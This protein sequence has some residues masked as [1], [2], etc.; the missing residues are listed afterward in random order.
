MLALLPITFIL[1]LLW[2]GRGG[3]KKKE[4]LIDFLVCSQLWDL[5][6]ISNKLLLPLN[7]T[8]GYKSPA[9]SQFLLSLFNQLFFSARLFL[10]RTDLTT[11]VFNIGVNIKHQRFHSPG[12]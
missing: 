2:R 7:K 5:E 4:N 11:S 12:K 9:D 3:G 6:Q 8:T 1:N 10:Q